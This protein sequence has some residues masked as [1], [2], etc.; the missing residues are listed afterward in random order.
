MRGVVGWALAL[1]VTVIAALAGAADA[2]GSTCPSA[3]VSSPVG[4]QEAAMVCFVNELRRD[5][6]LR[7]LRQSPRLDRA[8]EL[9]ANAIVRCDHF[10]H[11]PCGRSFASTFRAAGYAVGNWAGGEN[12]AWGAGARGSVARIFA[13]LL[14][15]A[16]HRANFL[17]SSWQDVGVALRH[18]R[19]FGYRS[20]SLWV[21]DFGRR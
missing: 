4:K 19:L 2:S 21:I 14:D 7:A 10:S 16:S 6:G 5:G 20:V 13:S 1:I 18:G 11:T 3:R 15:S 8:A 17:K 12:L 9:K